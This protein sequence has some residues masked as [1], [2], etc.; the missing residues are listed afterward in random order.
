MQINISEKAAADYRSLQAI[1][2]PLLLWY[3]NQARALPWREAPTPYRVWISEIMLQQT[4]VEAVKPY[5]DRFTTALPDITALATVPVDDLLKLWE[6]LGY[7]SRARNL[8]KAALEI[9]R[10]HNGQL[11]A[12]YP[13]L[14][15][16]PGIGPYT[17]GAIASIA[18]G[19]PMPAVDGNV[20]RVVM[21][22]LACREDVTQEKVK[23]SVAA[24]LQAILP[25]DAAGDFNQ[26]LMELGAMICLPKG[27]PKCA[28]CPINQI[29]LAKAQGSEMELPLKT[30]KKA[31]RIEEKTIFLLLYQGRVAFRKRPPKGLLAGMWE[32]PSAEGTLDVDDARAFIQKS[33]LV[34]VNIHHLPK[35]KHI[36]THIEWQM[37]GYAITIKELPTQQDLC[38]VTA[39]ELA[40]SFA[41]PS[42]FKVYT[43][44]KYFRVALE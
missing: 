14:L 15:T 38:W 29:C 37:T 11:P 12:S 44:P 41:V 5:F 23:K 10:S 1:V 21:R 34:P 24:Q 35:A 18:Y 43:Q 25:P 8:Q 19:I 3:K 28:F 13:A 26:A 42:A 7:Y 17:A 27:A 30:P 2:T 9:M 31:R 20:L 40:G 4:R 22:I 33:G 36:F 39:A 32:L 16:L 6:G